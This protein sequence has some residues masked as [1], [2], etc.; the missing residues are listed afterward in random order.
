MHAYPGAG[1]SQ[2][3]SQKETLSSY[4]ANLSEDYTIRAILYPKLPELR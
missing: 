1:V 4:I 2:S 3:V